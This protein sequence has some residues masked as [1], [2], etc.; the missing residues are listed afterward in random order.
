MSSGQ[1]K[2]IWCFWM[3]E[4]AKKLFPDFLIMNRLFPDTNHEIETWK[5]FLQP[6]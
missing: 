5:D 1:K 2:G 3:K 4:M 6:N